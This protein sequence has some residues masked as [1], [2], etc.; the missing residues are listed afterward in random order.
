MP[1]KIPKAQRKKKNP[2]GPPQMFSLSFQFFLCKFNT[3]PIFLFKENKKYFAPNQ[4]GKNKNKI[5]RYDSTCS[6]V[7]QKHCQNKSHTEHH[8]TPAYEWINA[9]YNRTTSSGTDSDFNSSSTRR[10]TQNL[11]FLLFEFRSMSTDTQHNCRVCV[12]QR[13]KWL[14]CDCLKRCTM[15]FIT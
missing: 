12:R 3:F 7:V 5:S 8:T 11:L 15:P 4:F 10:M 6:Y 1:Q 2:E 13:G 9:F 14:S